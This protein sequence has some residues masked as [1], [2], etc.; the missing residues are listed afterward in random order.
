MEKND[1][2]ELFEYNQWAKGRLVASLEAMRHEDLEKDLHS[3]HGGI[4][5][6]LLHMVSAEG[7]WTSRLAGE[8]VVPL[9]ESETK[10]LV[11]I[12]RKWDEFDLRLSHLIIG[13]TEE[14]LQSAMDYEDS[15]GN[16]YSHP[17]I[18]GLSQLFNHM[19]YHRGQIV[20]MQR[21]LGY[22]PVNTDLIGFYREKR[23]LP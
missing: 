3:S 21:Q 16:R 2:F 8:P 4:L 12:G 22:K 6:T 14:E 23:R 15:K 7:I 10:N 11:D 18:W 13:S 19:T 20:A 1:L 5:G 17:R 9:R